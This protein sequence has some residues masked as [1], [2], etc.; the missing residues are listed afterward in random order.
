MTDAM[1]TFAWRAL[2]GYWASGSLATSGQGELTGATPRYHLYPARDGGIVACAALEDH[3][4][5]RFAS[6]IGLDAPLTNDQRDPAAT[7]TAVAGIILSRSAEEWAP[8]FAKADCCVTIVRSLDE[9]L[10]DPH[11]IAR[12]LFA[13]R[14]QG[15]QGATLTA[16]PVPI[17]PQFRDQP[18]S[19]KASPPPL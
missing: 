1:F 5:Q 12:G 17:D 13:H 10:R 4:W 18:G 19:E 16:L 3:F 2:S 6:L 14:V 11:F 15:G 8:I 9:A 7:M